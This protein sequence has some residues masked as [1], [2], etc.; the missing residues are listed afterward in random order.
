MKDREKFLTPDRKRTVRHVARGIA[1]G[2][3]ASAMAAHSP[4]TVRAA[5]RFGAVRAENAA[6]AEGR[7]D[8]SKVSTVNLSHTGEKSVERRGTSFNTGGNVPNEDDAIGTTKH[9]RAKFTESGAP[10]DIVGPRIDKIEAMIRANKV[11]DYKDAKDEIVGLDA[12]LDPYYAELQKKRNEEIKLAFKNAAKAAWPLAAWGGA[13]GAV[14]YRR[15]RRDG[16]QPIVNTGRQ[17]ASN[18]PPIRVR[19]ELTLGSGR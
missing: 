17:N 5:L 14:L 9:A 16:A 15:R 18:Q 13:E 10:Q 19:G 3:A 12:A 6:L 2:V 11:P 4:D 1:V 7:Q 8:M